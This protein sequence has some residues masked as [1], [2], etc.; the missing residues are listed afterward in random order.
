MIGIKDDNKY[1][2]LFYQLLIGKPFHPVFW[3]QFCLLFWSI[4]FTIL[5]FIFKDNYEFII[6]FLLILILYLNFSGYTNKLFQ[7]YN[8]IILRSVKELFNTIVY[9]ISGFFLGSIS[10]LKRTFKIKLKTI[11][12]S[13]INIILID[14]SKY[15]TRFD[16]FTTQFICNI[17]FISFSIFSFDLIKIKNI[18]FIIKQ[19]SC[20]SGGI[21]YL[22]WEIKFRTMKNFIMI[23]KGNFLSC[24]I[25]Y[26]ICYI[27][28]FILYRIFKKSKLKYLFI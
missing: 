23:D 16:C 17:I 5:V 27:F 10:L 26:L 21:Y 8:L 13:F 11:F 1:K 7:D 4:F 25:I 15:K 12:I 22:H 6:F 19:L 14:Q 9:I 28:C 18:I 20:F 2:I 3:F 24:V